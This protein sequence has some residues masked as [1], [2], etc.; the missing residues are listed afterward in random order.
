MG[1]LELDAQPQL[2]PAW[3]PVV[4][5]S[6]VAWLAVNHS[7]ARRVQEVQEGIIEERVVCDVEKVEAE[8]NAHSFG[9]RRVFCHREIPRGPRQAP[10]ST[11]RTTGVLADFE[12]AEA[13]ED[14]LRI[15]KEVCSTSPGR[16]V[17]RNS[18]TA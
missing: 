11:P 10:N 13:V 3:G 7:K 4:A 6:R 8:A 18:N 15:G 1:V 14:A 16:R 17:T 12:V 5:V 9:D 2:A